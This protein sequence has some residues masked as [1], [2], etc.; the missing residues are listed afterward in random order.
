M[1]DSPGFHVDNLKGKIKSFTRGYLFN[2]YFTNVPSVEALASDETK[3]LVRSSSTPEATIDPIEIPWQG[4]TYKIGSTHTFGDWSCTFMVDGNAELLKN[5]YKWQ[6]NVHNLD[7]N[8]H[9][10]PED[11]LGEATVELLNVEGKSTIKYELHQLWPTAVAGVEI[12][13]DSKE[14]ST[15]DVTFAYQWHTIE[16]LG[17][18]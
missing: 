18:K 1:T 15:V 6:K 14:V 8:V 12:A 2:V 10:V 4:Q 7:T 13:Q 3:F 16:G 9:G 17:Y 11:Y 5:F